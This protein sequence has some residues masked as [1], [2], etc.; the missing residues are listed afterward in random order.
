MK[1]SLTWMNLVHKGLLAPKKMKRTLLFGI[2]KLVGMY[3]T[4]KGMVM[5]LEPNPACEKYCQVLK[6]QYAGAVPLA[7]SLILNYQKVLFKNE[8]LAER[9]HETFGAGEDWELLPL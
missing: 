1:K 5:S 6:K 9:Y 8:K 3:E 2:M 4:G 7:V